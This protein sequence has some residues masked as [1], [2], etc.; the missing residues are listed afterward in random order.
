MKNTDMRRQCAIFVW[1]KRGRVVSPGSRRMDYLIKLFKYR[2]A[3]VKEYWFVDPEKNRIT[4]YN[5]MHDTIEE[6][7]FGDIVSV[8]IYEDFLIKVSD[9]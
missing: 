4:V 2:N 1:G 9:M 8:G 3:G 7:A 6:Y 5:F